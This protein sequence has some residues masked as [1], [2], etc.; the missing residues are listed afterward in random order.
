MEARRLENHNLMLRAF[1]QLGMLDRHTNTASAKQRFL[2]GLQL[3]RQ[4]GNPARVSDFYAGLNLIY[5][6][7]ERRDSAVR[8]SLEAIAYLDSLG[9]D[10]LKVK[11][12]NDAGETLRSLI[13]M[14]NQ[15]MRRQVS[16]F[17]REA[18]RI[19]S[20]YTPPLPELARTY[21]R[22]TAVHSASHHPDA[23]KKAQK[24]AEK[25]L[26]VCQRLLK[27][28]PEHPLLLDILGNTCNE[29]A[30][31][32]NVQKNQTAALSYARQGLDIRYQI[33][34][35]VYI[36]ES[37]YMVAQILAGMERYQESNQEAYKAL[38]LAKSA[39]HKKALYRRLAVNY[40][41]LERW[42]RS[43][44]CW[45]KALLYGAKWNNKQAKATA[46]NLSIQ[47]QVEKKEQEIL[48]AR[49]R[50]KQQRL[51]NTTLLGGVSLLLLF[52]GLLAWSYYRR[53]RQNQKLKTANEKLL[54]LDN[55][56]R[57]MTGMIAHDLKNPLNTIMGYTYQK[58]TLT[59]NTIRAVHQSGQQLL[60]LVMNML[61]VQKFEEVGV[62]VEE[63]N[64]SAGV[65]FDKAREQI[66]Y[67]LQQKSLRLEAEIPD[68]IGIRGDQQLLMRVLVNLFTNAIKYSPQNGTIAVRAALREGR[69][70]WKV[71]DEGIGIPSKYKKHIFDRFGQINA[72]QSGYVGSTG[73]GLTFCKLAVE[74]HGGKIQVDSE[75]GKGTTF[76]FDLPHAQPPRKVAQAKSPESY[77]YVLSRKERQY[78]QAFLPRL[79]AHQVYEVSAIYRILEE[80]QTPHDYVNLPIWRKELE[81]T[82][83]NCNAERYESL[84]KEIETTPVHT[85]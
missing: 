21:N 16:E 75:V 9:I 34:D 29:L 10:S 84:L 7:M 67:L 18:E 70:H 81:Q 8:Y 79:R 22:L 31:I 62:Q 71:Q 46:K 69:V 28:T 60:T 24:Y 44:Q 43:A 83:Y 53:Q 48:L 55:F 17:F 14:Y 47:Y 76:Q 11:H 52:S 73:L 49:A 68:T 41:A 3:A 61:D 77:S 39:G 51:Q 25:A 59:A 20:S 1:F 33:G 6:T 15:D 50:N 66:A 78:L 2:T 82:L 74:A 64:F 32:N 35:S 23:L 26:D 37:H 5:R 65:L 63:E 54:Q 85:L 27:R 19:A 56:K 12:L 4:Q 13:S 42:K 40:K 38:P 30:H 36:L 72:T 80:M 58:S 45:E 57:Q